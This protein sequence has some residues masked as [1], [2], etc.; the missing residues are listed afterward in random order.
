MHT[1]Q[2]TKHHP[3]SERVRAL[4][5]ASFPEQERHPFELLLDETKTSMELFGFYEDTLFCGFAAL[6]NWQDISHIVYFA[7][8]PE[9]RGQ[10]VGSRVLQ[11]I[12]NAKRGQRI[13]VD[14]E[15]ECVGCD[16]PEQR[17]RRRQFYLRNGYQPTEIAYHW[18][19]DDYIILSHG[20][21]LTHAEFIGF[22]DGL[23]FV[24]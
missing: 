7:V 9:L 17:I 24:V 12:H 23:Q 1:E 22:W 18:H 19:G 10:G 11:T 2:I 13:I 21:P 8:P 20:G 5:E 14:I 15:Q 6:L 16:N 3:D 4:Y